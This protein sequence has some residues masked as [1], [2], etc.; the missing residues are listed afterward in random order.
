[1]VE[2]L[3]RLIKVHFIRNGYFEGSRAE[4]A[5]EYTQALVAIE[6]RSI[7]TI[8]I[9][10]LRFT[11]AA[12]KIAGKGSHPAFLFIKLQRPDTIAFNKIKVA[13]R[14]APLVSSISEDDIS[15][16]RARGLWVCLTEMD[17]VRYLFKIFSDKLNG[18]FLLNSMTGKSTKFA[19][20]LFEKKRILIWDNELPAIKVTRMKTCNMLHVGQ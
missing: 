11:S 6:L 3:G 15:T 2:R 19:E 5:R 17:K 9:V 7:C 12:L 18:L 16:R 8:D 1:M 13:T 20:I 4:K 10:E 14:E